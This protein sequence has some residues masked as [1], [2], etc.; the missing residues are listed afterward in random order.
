MTLPIATNDLVLDVGSGGSPHPAADVLLDKFAHTSHRHY[1]PLIVDRPT[2]LADACRMPFPDKAFDFVIAFH[3]LEHM[4]NP[5]SFLSELQR[6]GKAGY[7]ET[8]NAVFERLIPYPIHVLEIGMLEGKL[9]INKKKSFMPD[10]L[11]NRLELTRRSQRWRKSFYGN[12]DLFHVQYLWR[13]RIDFEIINPDEDVSWYSNSIDL[14]AE[15]E[16]SRDSNTTLRSIGLRALRTWNRARKSKVRL[17]E[18][19]VCPDCKRSL[20]VNEA[21][22]KCSECKVSYCRQPFP[23]FTEQHCILD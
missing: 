23:D 18:L 6:V 9:L 13:N 2:V 3:I 22:L 11:L 8:P 4:P 16:E 21:T 14:S 20:E 5:V 7:I 12:P 19:L 10:T 15:T 17:T 1:S